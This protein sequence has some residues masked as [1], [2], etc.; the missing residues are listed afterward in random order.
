MRW[1]AFWQPMPAAACPSLGWTVLTVMLALTLGADTIT[2][3][4]AMQP[5]PAAA[6][7][8]ARR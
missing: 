4:T 6:Y 8:S 2:V 1:R 7:Q 5:T 3:F